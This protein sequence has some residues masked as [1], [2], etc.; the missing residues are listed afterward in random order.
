MTKNEIVLWNVCFRP[1]IDNDCFRLVL[2][3]W[4]KFNK[5]PN[6]ICINHI[7]NSILLSYLL[8]LLTVKSVVFNF[9]QTHNN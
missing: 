5:Q 9:F 6:D 1:M 4:F 3:D 7:L 8:C 2:T